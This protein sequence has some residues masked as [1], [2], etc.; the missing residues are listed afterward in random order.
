[1]RIESN[2]IGN[3]SPKYISNVKANNFAK[4]IGNAKEIA[5]PETEKINEDEK[6]FF[7]N[8]YPENKSEIVDYH[9]YAKSGKMSGV[10]IGSKFDR[11]G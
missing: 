1:M 5:N 10:T 3:Y 11:R 2:S 6:N 9:F 7:I 4:E 8:L